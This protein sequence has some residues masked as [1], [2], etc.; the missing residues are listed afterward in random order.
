MS[1]ILGIDLGTNSIGWAIIQRTGNTTTL[2]DKGV[3]IFQE[4][5]NRVKG[6]EEP[7][8]KTRT[9][10]RASRRHYFRRRLRKIALISILVEQRWC[11]YISPEE[12]MNWRKTKKF[13]LNRDFI[14]WL[15]TDDNLND[16]PYHDRH[17]CLNNTLDL[18][19][20]KDRYSL[21][22]ALYHLN[23]RRGFLS[24][25]KDQASEGEN[26]KIKTGISELEAAM[27]D[28][29]YSFLGDYFYY[30]YQ[31]GDKIRNH[32]TSRN[33]HYIKEFNAICSKQKI[34]DSIQRRLFDAI[35]YQRPLKSQKGLVGKCPFERSKSRCAISHPAFEEFRMLCF[36]N[37]IRLALPGEKEMRP[38]TPDEKDSIIP[39]FFR[40]SR[41][42]F[43]F[44]DISKKLSGKKVT[45][46][47]SNKSSDTDVNTFRINYRESAN[48][49]GCPTSAQLAS[50]FGNDWK[51]SLCEQYTLA[52][53]KN[54]QQIVEDVW[55]SIQFFNDDDKLRE[56]AKEKL[57]L[58]DEEANSFIGIHCPQGYAAL[59]LCA[60]R[61]MLPWLRAGYRYDEAA[62]LANIDK[63]VS[64]K[65]W[66]DEKVRAE[67]LNTVCNVVSNYSPNHEIKNDSKLRKIEEEL[68][69]IGI[70][71]FD[72]KKLYHPSKIDVYPKATPITGGLCFLQSPRVDSIRNP[73]AMRSLFRLR[74]LIN[75]LI[76]EKKIDNSTKIN[77][78][79][80]RNLNDYNSRRA[81]EL[82]QRANEKKREGF[83]KAIAEYYYENGLSCEPT[84]ED[85]LKYELWEE[86]K[87]I[88]LYTG[89]QIPISGFLGANPR[90][91]IEHTI[92]RS[93]GGDNSKVNKTLCDNRFNREVKKGKLPSELVNVDD[94]IAR[95]D[96]T[97]WEDEIDKFRKEIYKAT[98]LAKS[99][100]DKDT[101]DKAIQR[102]HISR[103]QLNYLTD[104]LSRFKIKEVPEGFSNRQGVDIGII[105]RYSRMYLQTV[106]DKVYTVKGETTAEFRKM[107]G[108]Q[109][110]YSKKER[111]NHGHH[112][113]DAITIACIGK[114]EY[115]EWAKYKNADESHRLFG[116]PKPIFPK[117]WS[118]FTEDVKG[119]TDTL[120]VSHHTP[121][122][123]GKQTKKLLRKRGII[124]RDNNRKPEYAQGDTA[125]GSLH[126]Q[127]YYGAI[128]AND[129]IRYVVRKE[130]SSLSEK[131]IENIVD[132]SV[133]KI[134]SEA[135]N[136]KGVSVLQEQ[137]WMNKEKHIPIKKVRLFAPTIT[138]PLVLKNQRFKSNKEYKNGVY[139]ANEANFAY[140][141]FEGTTS[142]GKTKRSFKIINNLEAARRFNS[143][144]NNLFPQN[145][146]NGYSFIFALKTG[147][148][149]LFY[150]DSPEELFNATR[151]ELSK[152]LYKVFKFSANSIV[153][154]VHHQEARPSGEIIFRKGVWKL[155]DEFRP[156]MA[157]S[158]NQINALIEGR[159]FNLSTS[160]KIVFLQR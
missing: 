98:R 97:G 138:N 35:F 44:S 128:K 110:A 105:G 50:I 145:D 60:I 124:Q 62:M 111:I 114:K 141:V 139:V 6:N 143:G 45:A 40:K 65:D 119:I 144:E 34:D 55:H 142:S 108:L 136:A 16:N 68:C 4:G 67:I 89:A 14:D 43:D 118:T 21:G 77:I 117:P 146:E 58:S 74:S 17:R 37:N 101:K 95:I 123:M 153:H 24:N 53:G 126:L 72:L 54:E 76:A 115:E 3:H 18:S 158:H 130:L 27:G 134:V 156:I 159:D 103:M 94:I 7:S 112:C 8:V 47:Y 46:V 100:V 71:D 12:L 86:Q 66:E 49:C 82:M 160:G 32:Y 64:K 83:K 154:F 127:T 129:D 25:R 13:P 48:V 19:S 75:N 155:N 88:C 106:F 73:M 79:L 99:A 121:C 157:M 59:S 137:I 152:R 132:N 28:T 39:L 85:I 91:D 80:A 81:I 26:G 38:L 104:K 20:E 23:Q 150:E 42:N 109:D 36:V 33:E 1:N 29:G 56:W 90:F 51:R 2:L 120:L 133:R 102:R 140:G 69:N 87:H 125:R 149:V 135:V 5:V 41:A 31:K 52:A 9:E 96:V 10:A 107:W 57:Q 30:L 15:K 84:E 148:M 116:T 93:R 113:I 61:K 131:D 122:N 63:V 70:Y 11:P 147:T 92:P 151:E 22:R 78:E